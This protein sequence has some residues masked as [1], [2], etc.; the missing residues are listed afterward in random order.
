MSGILIAGLLVV[1]V[2][3]IWVALQSLSAQKKSQVIESQMS[4][5]RHDLQSVATA[6][7]QLVL[8][9]SPRQPTTRGNSSSLSSC[10]GNTSP[11]SR[12][13]PFV[14]SEGPFSFAHLPKYF[15]R[16]K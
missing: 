7:A 2:L 15:N 6:Q 3:V 10:A 9:V 5:L 4:E 1:A 13:G 14:F 11:I 12:K 16:V 8:Q